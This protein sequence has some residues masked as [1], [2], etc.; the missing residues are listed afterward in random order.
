M[1]KTKRVLEIFAFAALTA[2]LVFSVYLDRAAYARKREDIENRSGYP[3]AV[4]QRSPAFEVTAYPSGEVLSEKAFWKSERNLIVFTFPNCS[5]T[6]D[7]LDQLA[8]LGARD[9]HVV[10]FDVLPANAGALLKYAEEYPAFCF[11]AEVGHS[12]VWAYKMSVAPVI[13]LYDQEGTIVYRRIGGFAGEDP[14]LEAIARQVTAG[15]DS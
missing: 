14:E 2:I 5:A 6:Q 13:Y 3:P 8:G 11:Y 15:E 7:L 4:S 10:M 12:V 9:V 1:G